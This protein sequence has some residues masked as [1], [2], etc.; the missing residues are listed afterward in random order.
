MGMWILHNGYMWIL[1]NTYLGKPKET[2][3]LWGYYKDVE[4]VTQNH[5]V[6]VSI[7]HLLYL[8]NF[9]SMWKFRFINT[10]E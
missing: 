2:W 8:K 3:Q 6:K 5:Y 9:R 10:I 1:N 7:V 4:K